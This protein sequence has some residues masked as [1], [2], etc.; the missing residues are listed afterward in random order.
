MRMSLIIKCIL[1]LL[2]VYPLQAQN[3]WIK[4]TFPSNEDLSVVQFSSP[5]IGWVLGYENV[6][7]TEDGGETWLVVDS[8]A[9]SI[10]KGLYAIDDNTVVYFDYSI[11]IRRTTDGGNNWTTVNSIVEGIETFSFINPQLGFASGGECVY[12]TIDKGKTWERISQFRPGGNIWDLTKVSFLNSNVGWGASYDGKIFKTTD[13]GG[14]WITQDITASTLFGEYGVPL[15]DLQF[16]TADSGWAVGGI[17][18]NSLILRTINGGE[19]WDLIDTKNITITSIRDICMLN[20]QIGWFTG[21]NNGPSYVAKTTDGGITWSD[22]TPDNLQ[23]YGFESISM[24][25]DSVGHLVGDDGT[26]YRTI[27]QITTDVVNDNLTTQF[28][29]SQNYPNPFN[30][31]TTISFALPKATNV[32]IILYNGIGEKLKLIEEKNYSSGKHELNFTANDLPSGIY[33]YSLQTK[34]HF[35]SKKMVLLK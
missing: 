1:V 16:T 34:D 30:P 18:G 2:F 21:S 20:S 33:Y 11:G 26:Y 7:K 31:S 10:W 9:G 8:V 13:G 6:Y 28:A 4:A 24:I 29:L 19:N 14:N 17:S 12:K 15:R 23:V 32:K 27:K 3:Q 5:E 22:E 35:E 25:N